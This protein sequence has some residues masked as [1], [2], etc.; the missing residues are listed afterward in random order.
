MHR[1]RRF[2]GQRPLAWV[3]QE[4]RIHSA[5]WAASGIQ[6]A[7]INLHYDLKVIKQTQ[8]IA[9]VYIFFVIKLKLILFCYYKFGKEV[10][11]GLS[12]CAILKRNFFWHIP[13]FLAEVNVCSD[14]RHGS[15]HR[16]K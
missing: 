12:I 8:I 1:R 7:C 2:S 6:I 3:G 5:N 9:H 16:N 4:Y 11:R 10:G 15:C 13:P 14:S